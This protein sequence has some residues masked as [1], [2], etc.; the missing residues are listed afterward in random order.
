MAIKVYLEE[1]VKRLQIEREKAIATVKEKVTRE[2]IVPF[3]VEIDTAR[4]KAIAQRNDELNEEIRERQEAFAA[5]RQ[6]FIDS[7]E[8]KKNEHAHAVIEVETA[9]AVVE[10]DK[11]IKRLTEQLSEI[12]E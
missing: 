12:S 6:S 4:D 7:A 2:Q 5:E 9:L 8:K 10:Y 1:T 11:H 3:N